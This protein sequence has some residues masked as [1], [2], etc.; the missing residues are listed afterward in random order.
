MS[1]AILTQALLEGFSLLRVVQITAVL[2]L[3]P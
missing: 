1:G 2:L 3:Y